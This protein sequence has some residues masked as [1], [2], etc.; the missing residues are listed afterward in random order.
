MPDIAYVGGSFVP[1]NEARAPITDRAYY[2]ADAVYEVCS[3]VGSK[4][5]LFDKHLDRL[6]R[7]LGGLRIPYTVDRR[8]LADLFQQGI[9]LAGYNET[10]I[11][12]QVSRGCALRE[13]QF[14][15]GEPQLILT[16]REKAPM[17]PEKRKRGI[18]V[19]LV[20]DERWARCDLKTVMLLP[21]LLAYQN[22]LDRGKDDAIFYHPDKRIIHEATSAN[23]FAVQG[24]TV[25]TPELCPKLLAGT[26]RAYVIDLARQ[27]NIEVAERPVSVEQLLAADE[28]FLTGT[29]TDVL[30]VVRVDEQPIGQGRPGPM[31]RRLY[32]L[33]KQ[34]TGCGG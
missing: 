25:V 15:S 19:V 2:Y 12:L 30:G 6:E 34:T 20:P 14:P 17:P 8:L 32:E 5:F 13:K 27:N 24:D 31:T 9:A 16:F 21:N 11:Y 10:L 22:A 3:T 28:V 18:E 33:F 1:L 7:S 26:V 4:V 29:T 23:V